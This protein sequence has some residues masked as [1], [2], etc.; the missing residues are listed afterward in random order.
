[1]FLFGEASVSFSN[2]K[3]WVNSTSGNHRRADKEDLADWLSKQKSP[4]KS[5]S[6]LGR[7][8][9]NRRT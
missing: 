9:A 7:D 6:P 8:Q 2:T 4:V 1:M 5:S 3:N